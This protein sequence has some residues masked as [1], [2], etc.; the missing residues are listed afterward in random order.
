M[1][2]IV[3]LE[4]NE[5]VYIGADSMSSNGWDRE[6]TML[7]KVFK[8]QGFII[9]YTSSFRMGQILQYHLDIREQSQTESDGE[10]M[11]V[12]FIG[13]VRA[14]LKSEGYTKV[15]DNEETGGRFLVGYKGKLWRVDSDFQIN[16]SAAGFSAVGCGKD[17]ALGAM[18]ALP[19][20][21]PKKR[22]RRCLE[23]SAECTSGVCAPFHVER[24]K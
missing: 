8:V 5:Y 11:V 14:A 4:Q 7:S 20:M 15:S 12:A 21:P 3:G 19:D 1:T 16:R 24:L 10:Y 17:S 13:A 6:I 22:I 23:I 18:H 9:G 2:C